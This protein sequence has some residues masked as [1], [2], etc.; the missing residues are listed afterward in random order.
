M[1]MDEVNERFPLTKYKNWVA[2]RA[3]E[4]LPTAGGVTGPPSRT[5]SRNDTTSHK[6]EGA[7]PALVDIGV[8]SR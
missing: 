4:G 8:Q 1:T 7:R 2:T 6:E 5:G 3:M